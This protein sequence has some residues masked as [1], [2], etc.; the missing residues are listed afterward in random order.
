MSRLRQIDVD[1]IPCAVEVN[2]NL[3]YL[4]GNGIKIVTGMIES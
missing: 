3:R 4:L 2:I 1:Y